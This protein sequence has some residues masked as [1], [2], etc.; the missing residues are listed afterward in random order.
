MIYKNMPL[1]PSLNIHHIITVV[2]NI[3]VYSY[4]MINSLTIKNG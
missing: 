3:H 4:S 1:H 2:I